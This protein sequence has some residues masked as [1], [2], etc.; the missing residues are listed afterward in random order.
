MVETA[1]KKQPNVIVF[2]TDQQRWDTS[3]LFGNPLDLTPN[4]D[5]MAMEGTHLY[6]LFTPQPVCT[7]AR[8]CL[9][10]G[11]YASTVGVWKNGVPLAPEERTLAHHFNDA[12]Y[13]TSY[14]GKWHLASGGGRPKGPVPKEY[15]GGYQNWLAADNLESVSEPYCCRVFDEEDKEVILPGYRVDALTD[16]AI[17]QIDT[18]KDKPFFMFLSLLEPHMQNHLLQYVAPDNERE[19]FEGRWIPPD[20]AC[21]PSQRDDSHAS[22]SGE[23]ADGL[24]GYWGCVKRIDD[25]FGRMLDALKSLELLDNTIILFT[26]DHGSH[27]ATRNAHGKHSCHDASCRI[28]GAITGPGFNGGGRVKELVSLVDLPATLLDAC[29]IEIPSDM[30]GKSVKQLVHHEK[31][32]W[33]EEVLIQIS[34][35][36]VGRA[37]RTKRWKYSVQAIDKNPA[38]SPNSDQYSE[39]FLYDLKHD[40]YEIRNLINLDS[41]QKVADV[42]RERLIRRMVEIGED[43]PEI[44]QAERFPEN[45][46]IVHEDEIY[47]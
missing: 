13:S 11:K 34:Q 31:Q 9:Q 26:S 32:D 38:E 24:G 14:I 2:F 6:N 33:P 44:I 3:K 25:A 37:V 23:A 8:A 5:N 39:M 35:T 7:P 10:T 16:A 22:I 17:R 12:G 27:F 40:P 36:E 45:C 42:M 29:D 28:P 19:K 43:E 46:R 47:Q 15:R 20:L 21:L 41:H 4:F 30:Q 1:N 18:D